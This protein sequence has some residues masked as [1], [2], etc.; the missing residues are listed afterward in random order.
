M[1]QLKKVTQTSDQGCTSEKGKTKGYKCDIC[2][3]HGLEWNSFYND[4]T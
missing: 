2:K 4:T 1:W 3:Q